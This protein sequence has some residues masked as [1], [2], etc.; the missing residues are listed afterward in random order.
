MVK[1]TRQDVWI[2]LR[3]GSK[4]DFADAY[5]ILSRWVDTNT[6]TPRRAYAYLRRAMLRIEIEGW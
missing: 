5:D 4:E 1:P 2:T 6:L 3:Y